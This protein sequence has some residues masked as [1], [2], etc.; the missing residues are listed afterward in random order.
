M[1]KRDMELTYQR[2]SMRKYCS[3]FSDALLWLGIISFCV[4]MRIAMEQPASAQSHK[5]RLP[6]RP[7]V[8]QYPPPEI[9]IP[10]P[11]TELERQAKEHPKDFMVHAHLM[12]LYAQ[13]GQW[14]RCLK[15]ALKAI[16]IDN[17]D[18]NVHLGIIYAYA[19]LKQPDKALQQAELS[20]RHPFRS[21]ERSALLRVRG[22][23]LMDRYQRTK[24]RSFLAEAQGSYR[25]AL[26]SDTENALT[27][28]GLARVAIERK[29]L[30]SAKQYLDRVLRQVKIGEPGGRR[31]RALA[32]YYLGVVEEL[33]GQPMKASALYQQAVRTHPPSFRRSMKGEEK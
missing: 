25:K 19:N 14:E 31:K 9:E 2:W 23:L 11:L 27:L 22:D 1:Q 4:L 29:Q 24:K 10:T 6:A 32:L 33:Q 18:V 20:L 8:V 12:Y 7:V 3:I 26:E 13:Q 15:A 17:S 21:W 30:R 5:K 16:Q 28:I